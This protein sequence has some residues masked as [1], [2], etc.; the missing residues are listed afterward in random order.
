MS[1]LHLATIRG[2]VK[3]VCT[4]IERG[5]DMKIQGLQGMV[6]LHFAMTL[7]QCGN[8]PPSYRARRGYGAPQNETRFT[9]LHLASLRGEVEACTHAS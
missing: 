2:D 7:G 5:A 9:P 3:T 8:R 1:P 4:L 6:P